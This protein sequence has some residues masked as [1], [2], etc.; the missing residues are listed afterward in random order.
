MKIGLQSDINVKPLDVLK[1]PTEI[2]C[3]RTLVSVGNYETGVTSIICFLNIELCTYLYI[4]SLGFYS[5]DVM[6]GSEI[7]Y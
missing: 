5:L 6:K 2:Q 3:T 1:F 7:V 4:L